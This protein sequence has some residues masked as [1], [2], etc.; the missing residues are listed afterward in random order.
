M[1]AKKG[2][3]A[4]INAKRKRIAKGSGGKM[5]KPGENGAPSREDL[6][7]LCEDSEENKS[8][9]GKMRK[10]GQAWKGGPKWKGQIKNSKIVGQL[11]MQFREEHVS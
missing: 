5:R 11:A 10:C 1:P 6:K 4:N 9:R 3:Y 7:K 8:K 2:L